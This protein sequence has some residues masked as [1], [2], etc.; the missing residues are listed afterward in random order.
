VLDVH[1][2]GSL[3]PTTMIQEYLRIPDA[4]LVI[5]PMFNRSYPWVFPPTCLSRSASPK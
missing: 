5:W 1:L 2:P 4:K 3:T